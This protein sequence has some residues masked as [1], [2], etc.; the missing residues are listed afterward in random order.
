MNQL[1]TGIHL[2]TASVLLVL[3]CAGT[4]AD[5]PTVR[6]V[7]Q[8]VKERKAAPDFS[9]QDSSG[10]TVTLKE[11]RGKVV[12]LDFWATW[13]HGCKQEIPWFSEFHKT[14][15]AKGLA[16]VGVSMDEGGW[17]VVKPFLAEAHVP[18]QMLLGND[19]TAQRY[20]IQTMPDTYLIDQEGRLAAA[21]P[22]GVVD[23]GNVEANIKALLAKR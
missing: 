11:Y 12:L 19:A 2:V 16:V 15:G 13:C 22:G 9:L 6:A 1:L 18:Y 5:Q 8:S 3:A 17:N 14:Y 23:K 21:Y 10:K 20:R 4:A 7:L